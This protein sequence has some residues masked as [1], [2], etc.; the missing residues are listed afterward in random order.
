LYKDIH[1]TKGWIDDAFGGNHM[2][3]TLDSNHAGK[4]TG[5]PT[6]AGGEC[7]LQLYG[8]P[9]GGALAFACPMPNPGLTFV[10]LTAVQWGFV[11]KDVFRLLVWQP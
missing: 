4:F 7:A 5:I 1:S 2:K 8:G 9:T 3:F 11:A 10:S 6:C